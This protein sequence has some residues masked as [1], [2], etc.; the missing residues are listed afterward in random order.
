MLKPEERFA[1]ALDAIVQADGPLAYRGYF[2][3]ETAP[4]IFRVKNDISASYAVHHGSFK[5]AEESREWIDAAISNGQMPDLG[6]FVPGS[7]DFE[8]EPTDS[9]ALVK[10]AIE[11]VMLGVRMAADGTW[12]ASGINTCIRFGRQPT[13]AQLI[14]W[15]DK[16]LQAIDK[17]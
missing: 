3:C 8:A 7:D 1:Q 13:L 9:R 5:N 6:F 17:L 2:I 11:D 14:Q 16:L 12:S 15:Q 10:A 4:G